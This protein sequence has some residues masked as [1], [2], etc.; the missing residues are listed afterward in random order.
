MATPDDLSSSYS[1]PSQLISIAQQ[2][3]AFLPSATDDA[4]TFLG[5][6]ED[7]ALARRSIETAAERFCEDFEEVETLIVKADEMRAGQVNGD[8]EEEVWLREVFPR[9]GD[10]IRVLLS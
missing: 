6:L 2:L 4:R 1:D 5:Q 10:E 8:V 3:D 9:T 7:K